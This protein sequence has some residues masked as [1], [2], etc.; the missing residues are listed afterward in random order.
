MANM[1]NKTPRPQKDK[2]IVWTG[3]RTGSTALFNLAS[4][5]LSLAG[6]SHTKGYIGEESDNLFSEEK[7]VLLSVVKAHEELNA[8]DFSSR[9][10]PESILI[11]VSVRPA[12]EIAQSWGD[13][14]H[15]S[16]NTRQIDDILTA[17]INIQKQILQLPP[18]FEVQIIS[19]SSHR[20]RQLKQIAS[21]IQGK[22]TGLI[23]LLYLLVTTSKLWNFFLS[24]FESRKA[25]L[26]DFSDGHAHGTLWHASHIKSP[27]SSAFLSEATT[28]KFP[29]HT[30]D[31]I[32]DL[33]ETTSQ[34]ISRFSPATPF[35]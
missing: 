24:F 5:V 23:N 20:Y 2:I 31:L 14:A 22:N 16:K 12:Q 25:R 27:I 21:K 35:P 4:R 3:Y 9:E 15:R 6:T 18:S 26:G 17:N 28:K 19:W 33:D 10:S 11:L 29:D 1:T 7:T 34:I 13:L 32:Q 8:K 30:N